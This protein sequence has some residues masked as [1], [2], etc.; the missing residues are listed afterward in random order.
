M[1]ISAVVATLMYSFLDSVIKNKNGLERVGD[2]LT[3]LQKAFILIQR[4]I[5]QS[6]DRPARDSFGD[7]QPAVRVVNGDGF[8]LTR[9]G[10]SLP[11]FVRTQ[12]SEVQRV[13]YE[14]RDQTL[15]RT[16]WITPDITAD[17]TDR[18]PVITTLLENVE[19]FQVRV[20]QRDSGS[21]ELAWQLDWP[22]E[23]G[24]GFDDDGNPLPAPALPALMEL[25]IEHKRFGAM[26]RVLRIV[27]VGAEHTQ[28][29]PRPDDQSSNGNNDAENPAETDSGD[30]LGDDNQDSPA[31]ET[32]EE[33]P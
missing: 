26:R 20:A 27:G 1:A 18:N 14:F 6:V 17:E 7:S 29:P 12:R 22:P 3:R 8:E 30:P 33:E 24:Q 13:R 4:D 28:L 5:E 11:P 21:G 31:D 25:S 15:F 10:W 16:H 32:P 19:A 9:V 2:D 23:S